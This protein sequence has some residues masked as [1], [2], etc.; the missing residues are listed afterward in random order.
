[1]SFVHVFIDDKPAPAEHTW[2][3]DTKSAGP[4]FWQCRVSMR[5]DATGVHLSRHGSMPL[6]GPVPT[7]ASMSEKCRQTPVYAAAFGLITA[8]DRF[9]VIRKSK[10]A[11]KWFL[12]GGM[13]NQGEDLLVAMRRE[14]LEETGIQVGEPLAPLCAYE[15]RMERNGVVE[16]HNL[17][18]FFH[19]TSEQTEPRVGDHAEIAEARWVTRDEWAQMDTTP[20]MRLCVTEMNGMSPAK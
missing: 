11:G 14:V 1:M 18:V 17:M 12:P 2:F 6:Y 13:L 9:L 19:G 20:G 5:T 10:V 3:A 7:G 16:R 8:G 15:S 4:G